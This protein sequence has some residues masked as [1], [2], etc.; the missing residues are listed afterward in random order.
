MED[1][2]DDR[3][4]IKYRTV[5]FIRP[6]AKKLIEYLKVLGL[7]ILFSRG[8]LKATH[9]FLGP[10]LFW[11]FNVNVGL[12]MQLSD[13]SSYRDKIYQCMTST[14]ELVGIHSNAERVYVEVD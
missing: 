14:Q 5:V 10:T 1:S 4:K 8:M 2:P 13:L 6:I 11:Y 12:I 3:V 7:G 9:L